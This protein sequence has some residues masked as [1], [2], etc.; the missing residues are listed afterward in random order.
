MKKRIIA[1]AQKHHRRNKQKAFLATR[2]RWEKIKEAEEKAKKD[3]EWKKNLKKLA[4]KRKEKLKKNAAVRK[5]DS[6]KKS[7][8][9]HQ[10]IIP[11]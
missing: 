11:N 5:S 4:K 6:K 2:L 3:K 9:K 1:K 10:K 7:K 8:E